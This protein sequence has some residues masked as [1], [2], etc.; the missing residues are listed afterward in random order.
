MTTH[1]SLPALAAIG[2]LPTLFAVGC[3][4]P[5][6]VSLQPRDPGTIW[7]A[8]REVVSKEDTGVRVA[9]AFERENASTLAIGVEVENGTDQRLD[10]GPAD[11]TY[12]T[13]TGD[14]PQTCAPAAKVI[15]P[16]VVLDQLETQYAIDVAERY[17]AQQWGLVPTAERPRFFGGINHARMTWADA[18]R[19]TTL[20]PGLGY[21]GPVYIPIVPEARVVW[22]QVGIGTRKLRFCFSQTVRQIELPTP[23]APARP[24]IG[25]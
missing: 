22:L 12:A 1:R 16:E 8:G 7:I 25:P 13:C 11:V 18:Y 21:G 3:V 10:I 17:G 4:T 24:M 14:A 23:G 15:D 19:R 9:V 20:L 6:I 2:A 5:T